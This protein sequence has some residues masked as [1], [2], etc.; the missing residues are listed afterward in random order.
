MID[1]PGDGPK[2]LFGLMTLPDLDGR[3]RLVARYYRM[4]SLTEILETGLVVFDDDA[5]AF[6]KLVEFPR[7]TPIGPDARPIRVHAGSADYFYFFSISGRCRSRFP[8]VG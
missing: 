5:Q 7:D 1:I 3:E 4:K 6:R 2:W 8:R